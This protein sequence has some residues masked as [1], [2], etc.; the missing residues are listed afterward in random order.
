MEE[1]TPPKPRRPDFGAWTPPEATQTARAT[2]DRAGLAG[3]A[4]AEAAQRLCDALRAKNEDLRPI[5]LNNKRIVLTR[6]LKAF[7]ERGKDLATL[8]T[9][10]CGAYR[11]YLRDMLKRGV[12]SEDTC[13]NAVRA[14]NSTMRAVF[15]EQGKPGEGLLMK[16]FKQHPKRVVHLTE[17]EMSRLL[18]AADEFPFRWP[19]TRL[20]FKTYLEVSWATG[21]RFGSLFEGR[22]TVGDIDWDKQALVFRH[23]KNR[24]H[25]VA[26][27]T[28]RATVALRSWVNHLSRQ[29]AIWKGDATAIFVGPDGLPLKAAWINRSLRGVA[30]KAGIKKR[31]ST[32][33]IRKSVGTLIARENPKFAQLQLGITAEVFNEHYNQPILEDRLAK[34]DILP[35]AAWTPKTPE[36]VAGA[37]LLDM[38]NG[39]MSREAFE[40][41]VAQARA[42]KAQP[43][44]VRPEDAAYQ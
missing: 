43:K 9:D 33:I 36:E 12:Y 22:L 39:K 31:V 11:E 15:G 28:P 8:A 23:M 14:W 3:L 32:H 42:Q 2:L 34:R 18:Q 25:H 44:I 38:M 40:E 41:K 37:A 26:V 6:I 27:L 19:H 17:E 30:A 13:S 20:A 10:D 16:N 4:P 29:K 24:D 35:G 1:R 7:A 21:A 5:T